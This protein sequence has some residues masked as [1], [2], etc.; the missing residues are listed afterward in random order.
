MKKEIKINGLNQRHVMQINRRN[1][2][3][4]VKPSGKVYNRN[5]NKNW[6]KYV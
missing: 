5:K 2:I 4:K 1:T 6:K 3:T